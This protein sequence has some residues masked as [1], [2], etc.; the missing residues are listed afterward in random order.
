MLVT[1]MKIGLTEAYY[2]GSLDEKKVAV[3]KK[4]WKAIKSLIS[5][6]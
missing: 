1:V 3:N 5:N 4:F 2:Y 6:E